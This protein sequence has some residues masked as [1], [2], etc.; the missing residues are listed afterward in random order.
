MQIELRGSVD[1]SGFATYN[2][3]EE[4]RRVDAAAEQL[5]LQIR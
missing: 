2:S 5:K 3:D 1:I 4:E